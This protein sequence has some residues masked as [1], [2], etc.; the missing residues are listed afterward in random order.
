VRQLIEE[1]FDAVQKHQWDQ[2]WRS[3]KF[4]IVQHVFQQRIPDIFKH[5]LRFAFGYNQAGSD[6]EVLSDM[7]QKLGE[8]QQF[9][10]TAQG[11]IFGNLGQ[12][13]GLYQR[14]AV[15]SGQI[16]RV[17]ELQ[18]VLD[19]ITTR[20]RPEQGQ[21]TTTIEAGVERIVMAGVDIVTPTGAA[22]AAGLSVAVGRGQVTQ[23]L[24]RCH[25]IEAPPERSER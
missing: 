5:T 25:A 20:G 16:A 7:G 22:V 13:L 6:Q 23:S 15:L 17:A 1:K 10:L 14:A 3:F 21:G 4:G 12:L 18:E 24:Y 9:L 2:Q 19:D 11:V 8:G